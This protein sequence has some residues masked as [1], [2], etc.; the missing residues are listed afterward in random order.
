M[1]IA[2]QPRKLM[3][4]PRL[5]AAT[6]ALAIAFLLIVVPT[7]PAQAQTF[8][9]IHN[10][11]G[12]QDGATPE[13]GVTLDG[14]GN[15]Y[16][17]AYAG[18]V[19]YGTVYQLKNKS[20]WPS[21]PL[22]EFHYSDGANPRA[23]VIFGSNGTLYGTTEDGGSGLGT[24][25]NLR[26]YPT[27]CKTALCHWMETV[28]L[29]NG[30]D[31]AFPGYGDLLFYQ[32]DIFGTTADGGNGVG[33][34]YELT[35]PG[36]WNTE[37]VLYAFSGS[38]GAYPENG[39]IPDSTGNLYSTTWQGGLSNFGTVFELLYPGWAQQCTLDN[40]RNGNDGSYPVAGLIFDQS[41]NL[42]GATTYGGTGGGGT[43]FELTSIG[44]C[45]WTLNTIHSFT[46]AGGCGPWASLAMESGSLYGTTYCD[47][48][49]NAGN[50]WEL[51]P[52]GSSWIYTD[53]YDFTGGNDGG[54]PISNVSF[55]TSGNLYGTA[56]AGGTQGV[57]VV[58]EITP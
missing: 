50:V 2:R 10:F 24:V 28:L 58:W 52:S 9:V 38:D 20:G 37:T 27:V 51:T 14:A 23:R 4:D 30:I 54:N 55:D 26:P 6:A 13:A 47:G 39:V 11:T 42:Y 40:F 32:G 53:L 36:S 48:A 57:G 43:V 44:N 41:G 34:V 17:T 8:S 22:Y 15:V 7:Q 12:G 33:L 29:S 19:G 31:G 25:F 1:A 35:P 46:G 21:N 49:H 45:S 3:F 5:S 56:S 16:G 18:G